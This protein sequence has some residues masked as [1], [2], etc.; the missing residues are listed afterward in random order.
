M[1][2]HHGSRPV[3]ARPASIFENGYQPPPRETKSGGSPPVE[4]S[5]LFKGVWPRF[6]LVE[7]AQ[8]QEGDCWKLGGEV[9]DFVNGV[10]V[11]N[12][13]FQGGP[14]N[15]GAKGLKATRQ[16]AVTVHNSHNNR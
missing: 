1:K 5:M 4:K 16:G 9:S 11:G 2:F 8:I 7:G 10:V 15:L 13:D 6:T 14:F 12:N 3:G